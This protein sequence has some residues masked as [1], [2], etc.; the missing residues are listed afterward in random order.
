VH[1]VR[2]IDAAP[3]WSNTLAQAEAVLKACNAV[4]GL[5]L[6][7]AARE[8]GAP[9][10]ELQRTYLRFS[11]GVSGNVRSADEGEKS[12]LRMSLRQ[13]MGSDMMTSR[14]LFV[15][16][17]HFYA[18]GDFDSTADALMRM[19]PEDIRDEPRLRSWALEFM[20]MFVK[21]LLARGDF[22]GAIEYVEK[23]RGITGD[24]SDPSFPLAHM[25]R[26]AAARDAGNYRLAFE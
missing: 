6:L 4:K 24:D 17:Q 12:A 26:A 22:E 8:T 25:S 7:R 13:L 11:S 18:L 15:T 14:T 23:M 1:M 2:S 5:D 19:A 10:E 21:R 16:A 9:E 3:A 20:R